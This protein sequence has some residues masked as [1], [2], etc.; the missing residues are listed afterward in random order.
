MLHQPCHRGIS[1]GNWAQHELESFCFAKSSWKLRKLLGGKV[2]AVYHLRDICWYAALCSAP[3]LRWLTRLESFVARKTQ[4][5]TVRRK[6]FSTFPQARIEMRLHP[7]FPRGEG[8]PRVPNEPV[9]APQSVSGPAGDASGFTGVRFSPSPRLSPAAD[10]P[11]RAHLLSTDNP[12]QPSQYVLGHL[13][14]RNA[15]WP[16]SHLNWPQEMRKP[17]P[18]EASE[19][20]ISR[21]KFLR[22]SL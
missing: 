1:G 7:D 16:S 19:A 9:R 13:Q 3:R 21:T 2:L 17:L 22:R 15:R 6:R 12:S 11:L 5:Q 10:E 14:D 8:A 18:W 4:S 20:T